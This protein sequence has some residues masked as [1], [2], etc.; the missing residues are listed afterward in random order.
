MELPAWPQENHWVTG[1]RNQMEKGPLPAPSA[2]S[3]FEQPSVK[4]LTSRAAREVR[5]ICIG[6]PGLVFERAARMVGGKGGVRTGHNAALR[7]QEDT[8]LGLAVEFAE[9]VPLRE[10]RRSGCR[11]ALGEGHKPCADVD[12]TRKAWIR[13]VN[14]RR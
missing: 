5:S 4:F 6:K 1:C 13:E 7:L 3:G 8:G 10:T 11:V 9:P 14:A 12:K 2:T